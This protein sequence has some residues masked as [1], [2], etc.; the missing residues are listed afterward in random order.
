M[1]ALLRV[2]I[3]DYSGSKNHHR[4]YSTIWERNTTKL[5][6]NEKLFMLCN[7][8]TKRVQPFIHS[9]LVNF[10]SEYNLRITSEI[11]LLHPGN[12]L[13]AIYIIFILFTYLTVVDDC[14]ARNIH[15]RIFRLEEP[16]K[17]SHNI[18]FQITSSGNEKQQ[19]CPEMINSICSAIVFLK[20]YNPSS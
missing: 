6:R 13:L 4:W 1:S 20:D 16:S 12:E 11:R 9:S 19:N 15:Y 2:C 17:L 8:I 14:T 3:A 18:L 7:P 5:S 10:S